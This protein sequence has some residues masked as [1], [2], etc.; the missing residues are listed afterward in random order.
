L[1]KTIKDRVDSLNTQYAGD[2]GFANSQLINDEKSMQPLAY[3]L[4]AG[5]LVL[6]P[7]VLFAPAGIKLGVRLLSKMY[8]YF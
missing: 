1:L 8:A 5:Y 2:P 6:F 4:L 3:L 7:V